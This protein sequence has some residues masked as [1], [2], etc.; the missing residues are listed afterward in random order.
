[1]SEIAIHRGG[2]ACGAV[3]F[4]VRGEPRRGGLC[5]CMTCRKAHA[6]AFN[7]F[8]VL[9]PAAVTIE[10]DLAAWQSSPG[11]TRFFCRRCGSRTH[12]QNTLDGGER[13]IELSLGSF[14]DPG[15]F[16]PQYESWIVRREPWLA[17]LPTPQFERERQACSD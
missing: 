15:W 14:D 11:Y 13:E 4:E 3:R 16:R 12:A 2:C 5:H 6:A 9:D 10:G 7:P 17:A 1:M 8:V